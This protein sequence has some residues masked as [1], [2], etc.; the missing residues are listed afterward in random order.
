[1]IVRWTRQAIRDRASIFDYIAEKNPRAA[2]S[3]DG[4]FE[5]A[6]IQLTEFPH[7]G[8]LGLI[9]GTRELLPHSSYRMIY[10]VSGGALFIL[11]IVHTSRQWPPPSGDESEIAD[12]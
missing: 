7:S 11:T 4:A 9:E 1:M 5:Q 8:K 2:L 6:A 10:E 12:D 3:I